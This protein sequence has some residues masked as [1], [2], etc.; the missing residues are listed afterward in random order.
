M[1]RV[2]V[3]RAGSAPAPLRA[4][5]G[6]FSDWFASRLAPRAVAGLADAKSGEL[7][8]PQRFDG[9]LVTGSLDSVTRPEPWMDVLGRWLLAAAARRPVLGVCFGHQLLGRAL[10]GRVERHAGGPEAGTVEVELTAA[11]LA[12]PLFAGLPRRLAVQECHEDHL[13]E[14]PPGAVLLAH[15]RHA[16]VQAFAY[17]PRLRAVQF[18]PEF[19]AARARAILESDR[20]WLDRTRAGRTDETLA[21]LRETLDAERILDNWVEAC[22]TPERVS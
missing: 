18:H 9:I 21:G 17:G 22:V 16:P 3:V 4:R 8:D 11:G 10:G 15:N 13:P 6:D 7:P 19:D 14:L 5:M 20:A 1:K 12:D 2:L